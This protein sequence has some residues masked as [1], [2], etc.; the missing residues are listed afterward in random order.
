MSND[1][2]LSRL[3][4]LPSPAFGSR[5]G[6]SCLL[7]PV[8]FWS[9]LAQRPEIDAQPL[10]RPSP[11]SSCWWSLFTPRGTEFGEIQ[12][13]KTST[14]PAFIP[15]LCQVDAA[16]DEPPALHRAAPDPGEQG[17]G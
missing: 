1:C 17:E 11:A 13:K 7:T 14:A 8:G 5:E 16:A 9:G 3:V 4:L 10:R 2:F 15:S 12:A 6:W